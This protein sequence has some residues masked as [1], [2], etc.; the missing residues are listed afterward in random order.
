MSG[1]APLSSDST[2]QAGAGDGRSPQ[3]DPLDPP[4]AALG[5]AVV[6]LARHTEDDSLRQVRWFGLLRSALLL[7]EQPSLASLLGED[8]AASVA[9]DP[10]HLTSVELE[11]ASRSADPLESLAQLAWPGGM[12][13]LAAAFALSPG[14]WQGPSRDAG[15]AQADG[16]R[17][18]QPAA[19]E[20]LRA[21]VAVL[22]DGTRFSAVRQGES[23][24][25]ALGTALLPDVAE[26]LQDAV[27][28]GR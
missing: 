17:P 16:D 11:S 12:V 5:A 2:P 25:L 19:G 21:I 9:D 22:E 3:V 14:S 15:T 10:L 27:A 13:G 4:T 26:A 18:A 1:S 6:E 24:S 7:A 28:G 20:R 23:R 8:L